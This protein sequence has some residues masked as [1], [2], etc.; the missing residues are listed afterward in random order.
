[1]ATEAWQRFDC[2]KVLGVHVSAAP[3]EIRKA[4]Y[5]ASREAHPDRGGSHEAQ[6]R[7]NLA[8]EVLSDPITRQAHDLFW[9]RF[10]GPAVAVREAPAP[11]PERPPEPSRE[12]AGDE[13]LG[14]LLLR[15][16]EALGHGGL[17]APPPA[18]VQP[19]ARGVT[20][21]K[22]PPD[23]RRDA[24]AQ[25]P[26]RPGDNGRDG[27]LRR[28]SFAAAS[29]LS[30][31]SVG[32]SLSDLALGGA[33]PA[34][35]AL[36][37]GAGAG[38]LAFTATGLLAPPRTPPPR[39]GAAG[40][41]APIQRAAEARREAA[42]EVQDPRLARYVRGIAVLSGLLMRPTDLDDSE[43]QLARR[44]TSALFV[45]GYK[46][47]GYDRRYRLLLFTDDEERLL[48]RFRH[49]SGAAINVTFVQGMVDAMQYTGSTRGILFVSTGLS[50]NGEA[51][52][53][54]HG[55]RWYT[56][57]RMNDWIESVIRAR[58]AGPPGDILLLLD[59]IVTFVNHLS[60]PLPTQ[61]R[62]GARR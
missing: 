14:A 5:S 48:I 45:M 2:Y 44:I 10:R 54:Q 24:V 53:T 16:Q 55:V 41:P 49:R 25:A 52:A 57:A 62:A 32:G 6:V 61:P 3:V 34:L 20:G 35:H 37:L 21:V 17:A 46:P 12:P 7:A 43:D 18:A 28:W 50:G 27:R 23:A 39:A 30:G 51:L 60:T 38:W 33:F 26:G 31:L 58:Y 1:M 15:V 11:R 9:Y 19:A 22:P 40:D 8:Y 13:P 47:L 42:R 36:W 59:H 29:A 56:L 4:Y